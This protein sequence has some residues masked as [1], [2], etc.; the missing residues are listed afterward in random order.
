VLVSATAVFSRAD[1]AT[2]EAADSNVAG[3]EIAGLAEVVVTARKRTESAQ[4]TPIAVNVFS[5]EQMKDL[6]IADSKDLEAEVPSLVVASNSLGGRE[7]PTFALRGLRSNG[8]VT[9]FSEVPADSAVIGRSLYDLDSIQVLKGPQGTLFGQNTTA[10]ALLFGPAKPTS[11]QEGFLELSGGDYNLFGMQAMLNVPVSDKLMVRFAGELVNRSGFEQYIGSDPTVRNQDSDSHQSERLSVLYRPTDDISTLTVLD[12]FYSDEAP[13]WSK[14]VASAPCPPNPTI[15]DFFTFAACKYV[16]PLTTTFGLPSWTTAANA[17]LA[18]PPYKTTDPFQGRSLTDSWGAANVTTVNLTDHLTLKNIFGYRRDHFLTDQDT[19]GTVLALQGSISVDQNRRATDEVQ[20]Q[21]NFDRLNWIVGGYYSN[22]RTENH[23]QYDLAEPESPISPVILH[24]VAVNKSF[25]AYTQAT[26][27]VTDRLS[28]TAGYRQTWEYKKIDQ[29][30]Y[31]A[32]FCGLSPSPYVDYTTCT[33]SQKATFVDPSW[34]FGPEFK[35]TDHMLAY[36]TTRR[37][38][39]SGGFNLQGPPTYATEKLTDVE[40]GLKTDWSLAG[41]P[42]RTNL[43]VYRSDYTDIQRQIRLF[44]ANVPATVEA[45]AAAADVYGVELQIEANASRYFDIAANGSWI[46][47]K[48]KNFITQFAPGQFVNLSSNALAQAPKVSASVS[49]TFRWP[50]PASIGSDVYLMVTWSYQSRIFFE[51]S[52]QTDPFLSNRLDAYSQQAGYSLFNA[53]L[54]W[55]Q[56]MG[57]HADLRFFGKNL[58]NKLYADFAG[59]NLSTYGVA[60]T[61][62]GEPRTW[63]VSVAYHFGE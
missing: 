5:A 43:A 54:A 24:N 45:N 52:N 17:E 47:A 32:G 61:I 44:V 6:Q 1:A 4:S 16:P 56:V 57:T 31:F 7:R 22:E 11:K 29:S 40:V 63:G 46:D 42:V 41:R 35:L 30:E 13:A 28:L 51:D 23:G 3:D 60:D 53:E 34:T 37:G 58:G 27:K 62:Y 19:D 48:Y 26:Y 15:G 10:G 20:L 12:R 21:G 55:K 2:A 9:Y 33:D 38:F 39:N 36:V 50:V 49:P 8:V 59:N 14:L 18:L 25:A